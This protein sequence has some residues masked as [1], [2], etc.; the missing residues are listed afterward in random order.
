MQPTDNSRRIKHQGHQAVY[1]NN[2]LADKAESFSVVQRI[3][4]LFK[5]VARSSG[6]VFP[7]MQNFAALLVY[8]EAAV[9]NFLIHFVAL[10]FANKKNIA[11]ILGKHDPPVF[12]VCKARIGNRFKLAKADRFL[13]TVGHCA[14]IH[15]PGF[16]YRRKNTDQAPAI[17]RENQVHAG[18]DQKQQNGS[19]G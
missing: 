19:V 8:P 14:L 3:K 2:T 12:D 4:P 6:P 10:P 7:Y 18:Q 13:V 11:V 5:D 9:G 15:R 1:Q 16:R 17:H